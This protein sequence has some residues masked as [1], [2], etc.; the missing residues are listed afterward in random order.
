MLLP[1]EPSA[2]ERSWSALFSSVDV[3]AVSLSCC[4]LLVEPVVL[5]L[6]ALSHS[7][8]LFTLPMSLPSQAASKG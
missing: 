1:G 5:A 4:A 7:S 3:P 2:P 8:R 6:N